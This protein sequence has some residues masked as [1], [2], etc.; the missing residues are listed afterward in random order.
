MAFEAGVREGERLVARAHEA[1]RS[2]QVG[3]YEVVVVRVANDGR[4]EPVA[5]FSGTVFIKAE[6]YRLHR[7]T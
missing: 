5:R 6:P 4:E 2:R 3:F 1:K 7:Q